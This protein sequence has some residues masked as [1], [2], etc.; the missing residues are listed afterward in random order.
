MEKIIEMSKYSDFSS[1]E[2]ILE[3]KLREIFWDK[4]CKKIED[5]FFQLTKNHHIKIYGTYFRR[6]N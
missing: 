6:N 3:R 1:K 4:G 2:Y 5:I